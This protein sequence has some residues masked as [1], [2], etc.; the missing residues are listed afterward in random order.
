MKKFLILALSF[1]LIFAGCSKNDDKCEYDVCGIVAPDA[2]IAAVQNHI[3]TKGI[4]AERHCSG[5]YYTVEIAGTGKNPTPCSNVLIR[6]KGYLTNDV[7]FA[8]QS[9][10]ESFNLG[11]L[12][13]GW[14]SVLP[15]LKVGGRIVLYIPPTLG[16]G[17]RANG[18]I[19]AN[20]ILIFEIELVDV[21]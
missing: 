11:G 13:S 20:S 2:E 21:E 12:I 15:M 10:V 9:G 17:N 1:S 3:N 5:V 14:R 7:V 18:Q 8:P 6:Y 19:P 16:Y 4:V